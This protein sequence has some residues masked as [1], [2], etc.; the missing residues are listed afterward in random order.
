MDFLEICLNFS[1]PSVG[2][3]KKGDVLCEVDV[4]SR[5]L[6]FRI[7]KKMFYNAKE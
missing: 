4:K 1:L 7:K 6:T 2:Q 3:R 5:D